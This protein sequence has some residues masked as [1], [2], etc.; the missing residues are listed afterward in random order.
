MRRGR[1]RDR[2]AIEEQTINRSFGCHRYIA[3]VR[4]LEMESSSRST[5]DDY[6][7]AR[8]H[9][10][11]GFLALNGCTLRLIDSRYWGP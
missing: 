5:T 6:Y 7:K 4:E 9:N 11:K 8:S 2:D 3:D 10:R 1:D